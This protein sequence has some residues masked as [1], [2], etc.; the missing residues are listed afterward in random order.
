MSKM[1]LATRLGMNSEAVPSNIQEFRAPAAADDNVAEIHAANSEPTEAAP[2]VDEEKDYF[3]E[4]NG[5]KYA[6]THLLLDVWGGENLDDID[7]I[8]AA[9]KECVEVAGATLLHCH[10]HHF[11]PNGGVT[12]VLVLAESHISIH[13]WPEKAYAALDIFMCGDAEPHKAIPVLKR[14]FSPDHMGINE[15]KRGLTA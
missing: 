6:G 14:A 13:T 3:I 12:G 1:T 10:L 4:H 7:H 2:A 8:E 5:M 15:N 9:L 11:T